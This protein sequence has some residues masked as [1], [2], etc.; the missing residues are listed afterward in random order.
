[1]AER[2]GGGG[3]GQA[4]ALGAAGRRHLRLPALARGRGRRLAE[5]QAMTWLE[6]L[7]I[8]AVAA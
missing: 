4:A 8:A 1:M 2:V 6:L 3:A 7:T 5:I